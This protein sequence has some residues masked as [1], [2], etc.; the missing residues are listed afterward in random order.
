[1]LVRNLAVWAILAV[2]IGS[3]DASGWIQPKSLETRFVSY[4]HPDPL[5]D[6]NALLEGRLTFEGRTAIRPGLESY[7]FASVWGDNRS[8]SSGVVNQLHDR[9][10]R[11]PN[12]NADEAYL[13]FYFDHWDARLGKQ[14]ISWGRADGMNPTDVFGSFDYADLLAPDRLGTVGLRLF[15]YGRAGR[16]VELVY[17]PFY[18]PSRAGRINTRWRPR[19][20]NGQPAIGTDIRFPN[21]AASNAGY[22]V[23]ISVPLRGWEVSAGYARTIDDVAG[24]ERL[25]GFLVRPMFL[26]KRMVGFDASRTLDQSQW[27]VHAEAAYHSTPSGNDD[28]YVQAVV[29]ARRTF[30]DIYRTTD[31]DLTVELAG[32]HVFS[33]RQNESVI[34]QNLI[35]RPFPGSLL[36]NANWD[37]TEFVSWSLKGAY[38]FRSADAYLF[39]TELAWRA[40]DLLDLRAGFDALSG[41]GSRTNAAAY[42]E[43]DRWR[44]EA[45]IY[46]R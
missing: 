37:L 18:S 24:G 40:T 31:L 28:D 39:S 3:A 36:L 17:V 13:N 43:N 15:G 2:S 8:L 16:A 33:R 44:L 35:Q 5:A 22:G 14:K 6:G 21:S 23:K 46:F 41:N 42:E 27:E 26:K 9:A 32:E 19:L 7:V 25:G 45:T 30:P 20:E 10:V 4:V 38:T 29:G 12:V 34:L 1:M 11:R